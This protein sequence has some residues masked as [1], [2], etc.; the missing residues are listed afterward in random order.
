MT[1]EMKEHVVI[2]L[3]LMILGFITIVIMSRFLQHMSSTGFYLFYETKQWVEFAWVPEKDFSL[4]KICLVGLPL[5]YALIYWSTFG[6][7]KILKKVSWNQQT[8]AVIAISI[9]IAVGLAIGIAEGIIN[10]QINLIYLM[11]SF[12]AMALVSAL[13]SSD[14]GWASLVSFVTAT[15]TFTSGLLVTVHPLAAALF[16]LGAM[17]ILVV[18]MHLLKVVSKMMTRFSDKLMSYKIWREETKA[19]NCKE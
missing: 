8:G 11:W 2:T 13:L 4:Y 3:A 16:L 1:R 5:L 6:V 18:I 15:T 17:L 7:I 14:L 19:E 10:N 12:I 9:G